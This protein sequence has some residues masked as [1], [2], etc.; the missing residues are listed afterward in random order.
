MCGNP[1]NKIRRMGYH[2]IKRYQQSGVST[3]KQWGKC[4]KDLV[5][6]LH[7]KSGMIPSRKWMENEKKMCGRL[8]KI[9]MVMRQQ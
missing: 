8:H 3:S 1:H 2:R 7:E 4:Y 6:Q 9:I 5:K